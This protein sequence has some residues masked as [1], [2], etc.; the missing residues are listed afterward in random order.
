MS[1]AIGVSRTSLYDRPTR[2]ATKDQQAIQELQAAHAQ[3]PLYG[4]RRLALHL[5]WRENK[6]RRIRRLSSATAAR[7]HRKYRSYRGKPE[8][9]APAN[10]LHDYTLFKNFTR[11]QDGMDYSPMTGEANA[12]AQDFTYLR[13]RSGL[14]Y[15]ALVMDLSTR[16]VLSWKLGTNH[17]SQLTHIAL[18]QSLRYNPS[19]SIL[20]SDRGS[21]YLS[22]RHHRLPVPGSALSSAP[23]NRAVHGKTATWSGALNPSKKS[24][25]RW[26][27]TKT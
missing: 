14:F 15:L 23:A 10:H 19:P 2:L 25:A 5:G 7:P 16:E 17:T 18:I 24:L 9:S 27:V 12:W 3:H 6:T 13:I 20:H 11:P 1:K 26:L 4:V 22:E 8:I 21:E